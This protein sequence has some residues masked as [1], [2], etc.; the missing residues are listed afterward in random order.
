MGRKLTESYTTF[1]FHTI[2]DK[3]YE[4]PAV[5]LGTNGGFESELCKIL[6]QDGYLFSLL[7]SGFWLHT[8]QEWY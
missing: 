5:R 3:L 1:I 7:E 2:H 4:I 8:M 6:L